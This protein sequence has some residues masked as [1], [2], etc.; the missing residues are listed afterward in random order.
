MHSQRGAALLT[1]L[2][3][4]ALLS[5]ILVAFYLLTRME[6]SMTKSSM[7]GN[8]G[9]YAAEAGANIRSEAIRQTFLGFA[10][11]AGTPPPASPGQLPCQGG[12]GTGDFACQS[13]PFKGRD[14][15]T[16]V[17][18]K[19]GG[20]L[21]IT[22]PAGEPYA[23][24]AASEYAYVVN[25]V[26]HNPD[27]RPEAILEM[28]IKSRVVPMF[29]FIAFFNKD[30]EIIPEPPMTLDGRVHT[31]GDLYLGSYDRLNILDKVTV[32]GDL[33]RGR[34][35]S[36]NCFS[37]NGDVGL[38]DPGSLLDLPDCNSGRHILS[39][40]D[41]A[42]WNGQ[43]RVGLEPVTVPPP[44]A[45][46]P[47]P[48]ELYW[49][50][51]DLR[52]MVDVHGPPTVEVRNVDGTLH[53]YSADLTTCDGDGNTSDNGDRPITTHTDFYSN[54]EGTSL[55][56]ID[57]DMGMLLNCLRWHN[58]IMDGKRL[59]DATNGG[60]VF[61]FGIDGPDNAGF[62]NYAVRVF[63]GDELASTAG[64]AHDVQGLT[65]VT[66]QAVFVQGHYNRTNKVPAAFLGDS[67][68]ILSTA[69]TDDAD[70]LDC[71]GGGCPSS[72][73]AADTTINAAFLAGSDTTAGIEGP[74]GQDQGFPSYSGGLHNFPRFHEDWKYPGATFTYNGSFVSLNVPQHVDGAWVYGNPQYYPPTRDWHYDTDFDDANNLPPLTPRF[75]YIRQ[76]LFVRKFEL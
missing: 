8:R 46:D 19:P 37:S 75:T 38:M 64:G 35:H 12:Q 40:S 76:E 7:D 58:D 14:V 5:A 31:N 30:L 18:E 57:I 44:E 42:P 2:S 33:Y 22:I 66:N 34:K 72:R 28:H 49:D 15:I 32:V 59:D 16:Y 27:D 24:L 3:L 73:D 11:P 53:A 54:R 25:S 9:Y 1:V 47:S 39:Q 71:L 74:G 13:F 17:S 48:G 61:Y 63:N 65:V 26:A 41:L 36:S 43:A 70:A 51:A 45:L 23:Y 4:I 55:R 21:A 69:W 29:Q 10:Q 20:P 52:V 56:M 67:I 60:L 62:N 6:M 50:Y 68:N